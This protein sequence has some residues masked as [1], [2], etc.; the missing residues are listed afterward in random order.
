MRFPTSERRTRS[1]KF[2]NLS[3]Y[4]AVFLTHLLLLA[5]Q[6][7]RKYQEYLEITVLI[8]PQIHFVI[9][10]TVFNPLEKKKKKVHFNSTI[11]NNLK[12]VRPAQI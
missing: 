10:V 8:I 11:V 9:P 6:D 3:L 4:F 2:I 1:L 5:L 12:T 7:N